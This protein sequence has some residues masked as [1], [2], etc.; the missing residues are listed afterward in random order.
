[1]KSTFQIQLGGAPQ[2][3]RDA[4]VT[5]A[6]E[7]TGQ[8]LQVKPYLDGSLTV[9]DLDPGVWQVSVDHP[10]A[11]IPLFDARVRLFDQ[12]APTF[13][14]ITIP[15]GVV[16]PPSTTPIA[17][18]SPVQKAVASA[19]DRIQPLAGKSPGE[20][21]RASDWNT[22]ASAM[23]DL[24]AAVVELTT[25]VAPLGHGHADIESRIDRVQ[26]QLNK[27]AASF[28]RSQLQTQRAS[29]IKDFKDNLLQVITL[30]GATAA[31]SKA[32]TDAVGQ[33]EANIDVD[34]ATFTSMLTNASSA[35]YTLVN[36]L[37]LADPTIAAKDPV[38]SL[39]D[40]ATTY[41]KAGVASTPADETFA[42]LAANSV[43]AAGIRGR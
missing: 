43:K 31:Q 42:Y 17:D 16:P 23:V 29:Q 35:S 37:A 21:I 7:A 18:M 12:A 8:K 38:K 3:N 40:A 20:V 32:A 26:D 39:Q 41:T 27:F 28:G 14:P 36:Q 11:T 15:P 13:V 10:N 4:V 2:A 34:S 30:G 6:N 5:L 19:K 24:A 9:R 1:M 22:M 33:L 25:L